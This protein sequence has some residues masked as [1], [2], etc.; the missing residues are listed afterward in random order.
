MLLYLRFAS[1]IRI[2]CI[3][4]QMIMQLFFHYVDKVL[5]SLYYSLATVDGEV[6]VALADLFFL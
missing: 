5:H 3:F 6:C 4:L 2:M 1:S